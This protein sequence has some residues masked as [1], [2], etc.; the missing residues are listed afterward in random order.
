MPRS[1]VFFNL[2]KD[3]RKSRVCDEPNQRWYESR[4]GIGNNLYN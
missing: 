1:F 2:F 3:A 4:I